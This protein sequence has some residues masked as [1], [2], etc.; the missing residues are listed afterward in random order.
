M[1]S[2]THPFD[3][4]TLYELLD[5]GNVRVS[6]AGKAGVFNC[7]GV[8]QSGDIREADP[9]VCNWVSNEPKPDTQLSTSRIAGR[10]G[11]KKLESHLG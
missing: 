10:D 2:L 6:K 3:P 9:Q 7:D 1:G 11:T 5:D 4:E 8:Y